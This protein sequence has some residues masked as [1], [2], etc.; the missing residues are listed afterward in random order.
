MRITKAYAEQ[1]FTALVATAIAAGVDTE[2]WVLQDGSQANGRAWRIFK[3]SPDGGGLSN[4]PGI[5]NYLGFT[6]RE[7]YFSLTGMES[8]LALIAYPV[9]SEKA[10]A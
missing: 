10:N 5:G 7:A 9:P 8:A 6:A 1:A 3:K 2:G 4:L